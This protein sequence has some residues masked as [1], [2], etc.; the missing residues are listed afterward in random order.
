MIFQNRTPEPP[1]SFHVCGRNMETVTTEVLPIRT[2]DG[3]A[4][5][6]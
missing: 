5:F 4:S 6:F 1:I 2:L 3:Q